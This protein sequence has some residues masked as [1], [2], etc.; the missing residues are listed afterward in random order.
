MNRNINNPLSQESINLVRAVLE[1]LVGPGWIVDQHGEVLVANSAAA[2]IFPPSR[3][4]TTLE[5]PVRIDLCELVVSACR[6]R[7]PIELPAMT[8]DGIWPQPKSL[9]QIRVVP[10]DLPEDQPILLF[11]S[12]MRCSQSGEL[13]I[14]NIETEKYQSMT[15]LAAK[16]AH[17]LNN[18]LDGSLRYIKLAMRRLQ[19]PTTPSN[20]PE[21]VTEY[22]SSAQEAL[23][24]IN[25]ILSDLTQFA[26]H[27][28]AGIETIS[29][30]N[31]VEQA[32][33]TLSARASLAGVSIECQLGEHIPHA[34][35]P[36][37]YQV[38][39]N[40][41]KNAIDA[42][43]EKKRQDPHAASVVTIHTERTGSTVRI[44]F[45]DTGTGLPAD[46]QYLFDP[47]FT[48]KPVGEGTGLGL[49]ISKEIVGQYCGKITAG[50]RPT[51]GACF[52]VE[53]PSANEPGLVH[54]G[55]SI[56]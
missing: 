25:E 42:V 23:G 22:L 52:T 35:G 31:L 51:G 56:Q 49:A 7:Q 33:R 21:K 5:G 4:L 17:E 10:L 9:T 26:R 30:N 2:M 32:V 37:L 27:G 38:F 54:H 34:G 44:V 29:I 3:K 12:L 36:K 11:V 43:V 48:T 20:P 24:K 6:Q 14:Q 13:I 46:R 15:G 47:F 45:E 28:Q 50:D 41:L 16:I 19:Q 40:L 55:E 1:A 53:I 39:C 18:P 8:I